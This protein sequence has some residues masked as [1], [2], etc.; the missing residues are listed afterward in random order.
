[1][2]DS[3]IQG[4]HFDRELTLQELLRGIDGVTLVHSLALWVGPGLRLADARG[5]VLFERTGELNGRVA[6]ATELEPL[7]YLEGTHTEQLPEAVALLRQLLLANAR[8]LMA[9][10][11]HLETVHSDY[12][13]LRRRNTALQA[14]EARSKE[15]AV[16][17]E[18][19][20]AEQIKIIEAAQR[21]LYQSEKLASV[22]QL[23][24][25]VAHEIN[26][27]IGF[28][29]SNLN[30]AQ[31]Y[32]ARFQLLA[33]MLQTDADSAA[34]RQVWQQQD[35]TFV[36]E[37][38]SQLL[39]ESADGATRVARIVADL[40]G[41]SRV[42]QLGVEDADLNEMINQ[43]CS[44]AVPQVRDRASLVL[45]LSPLP[46]LRCQAAQLGQVF[47]NLLL[48]AVDAVAEDGE[49]RF[50]SDV[51]PGYLRIRISD[52]GQGIPA[53]RIDRIFDPFYTSKA[54]GKGTGLGLTVS[55]DIVRA[56]GG[57]LSV[58]SVLGQGTTFTILLP[59][60][61]SAQETR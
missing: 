58:S 9:S 11:L 20:V 45:E 13:E 48:N 49:I 2:S 14:S 18:Q 27:P 6:V 4:A 17:L 21:Q 40:K 54:V 30:M 10:E 39:Q 43:V 50:I 25:G 51:V 19:R 36:L 26:N 15:L 41:F 1:M 37:D 29:A 3:A 35:L 28:I 5:T 23:A 24:A 34:L 38:F 8:Y 42:D 60:Q 12:E 55:N 32:L 33:N 22:G 44:V 46:R 7:G 52:N 57:E 16:H 53:D 56:H 61:M 59:L 31:E 47:L